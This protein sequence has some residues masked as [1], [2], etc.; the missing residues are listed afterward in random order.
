MNIRKLKKNI[1]KH[2]VKHPLISDKEETNDIYPGFSYKCMSLKEYSVHRSLYTIL[3]CNIT[4]T[5]E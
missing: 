3:K 1:K 4:V 2:F 5:Q